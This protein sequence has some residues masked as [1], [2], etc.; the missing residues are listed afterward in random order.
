[1]CV[2]AEASDADLGQAVLRTLEGTR[3]DLRHPE[4]YEWKGVVQ[5]LLDLA[6]THSYSAFARGAVECQVKEEGG[7]LRLTPMVNL[8]GSEGFEENTALA[9]TIPA[10]SSPE[11]VGAAVRKALDLSE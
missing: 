5:P 2:A 11:E 1:M 3:F 10:S 9:F 6:G 4:Q 8:G 7:L